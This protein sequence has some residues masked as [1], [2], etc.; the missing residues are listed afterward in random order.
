VLLLKKNL[1]QLKIKI[2]KTGVEM[3]LRKRYC[4]GCGARIK[5]KSIFARIPTFE[6]TKCGQ[7]EFP[8][9]QRT[10]IKKEKNDSPVNSAV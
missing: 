4:Q 10:K 7:L 6:C 5:R 9:N 8:Q 2:E 1:N 3:F